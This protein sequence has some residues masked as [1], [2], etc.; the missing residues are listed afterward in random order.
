M[1]G[2]RSVT[3]SRSYDIGEKPLFVND[4]DRPEEAPASRG[5]LD[6]FGSFG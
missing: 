2:T 4:S 3:Q 5:E 1:G 6:I